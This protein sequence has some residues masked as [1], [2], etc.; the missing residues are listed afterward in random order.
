MMATLADYY[1]QIV[2][3][4]EGIGGQLSNIMDS[5]AASA[6]TST[7]VTATEAEKQQVAVAATESTQSSSYNSY[8]PRYIKKTSEVVEEATK[9]TSKPVYVINGSQ[10]AKDASF[11]DYFGF[12][13]NDESDNAPV[14][15]GAI[16]PTA[17]QKRALAHILYILSVVAIIFSSLFFMLSHLLFLAKKKREEDEEE[18]TAPTES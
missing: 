16:A 4:A 5:E 10:I 13:E 3:S 7:A 9:T 15:D 12:E 1:I 18:N 2:P 8:R 6:G 11:L 17:S 14:E